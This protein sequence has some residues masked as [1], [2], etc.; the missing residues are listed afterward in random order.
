MSDCPFQI[1][2]EALAHM[3]KLLE[4]KGQPGQFFRVGVKGGGCSGFEYVIKL[5]EKSTSFD[6]NFDFDGV[7]VVTD[8]RSAPYITD[9]TIVF[10]NNLMHG[11]LRFDNP[12]AARSCGC[13]SS[14][15]PKRTE[16]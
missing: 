1:S 16:N 7:P 5:D 14:F 2:P 3:R 8:S 4:R 6:L 13:G 15:T 12:N 10:T 11:G 9:A